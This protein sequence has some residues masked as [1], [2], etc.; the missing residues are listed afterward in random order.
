MSSSSS[1]PLAALSLKRCSILKPLLKT[2][3][4]KLSFSITK[5]DAEQKILRRGG[6]SICVCERVSVWKWVGV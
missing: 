3:K 4:T 2:L 6:G 5:N 1:H